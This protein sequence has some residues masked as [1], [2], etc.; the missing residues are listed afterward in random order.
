[1]NHGWL[2]GLHGDVLHQE[3]LAAVSRLPIK[4]IVLN[5]HSLTAITPS[6]RLTVALYQQN[7]KTK[8][9]TCNFRIHQH[10]PKPSK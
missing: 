7:N 9:N 8:N 4:F 2:G 10:Q 6:T 3:R 5:S 1:M